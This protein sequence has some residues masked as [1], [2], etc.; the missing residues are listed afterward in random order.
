MDQG[1]LLRER[2]DQKRPTSETTNIFDSS[3]YRA[4][5]YP[6]QEPS[7]VLA[8]T[9]TEYGNRNIENEGFATRF[10]IKNAVNVIAIKT[11]EDDWYH[12]IPTQLF[13]NVDEFLASASTTRFRLKISYGS[14]M[15]GYAALL[16]ANRL[17]VHRALALSPQ[18]DITKTWDTRW[19]KELRKFT[20][21]RTMQPADV[22]PSCLYTI[23]YDPKDHDNLHFEKFEKVVPESQLQQLRISYG[24]HPTGGF[25]RLA[26]LLKEVVLSVINDKP[27]QGIASRLR[28][29]RRRVSRYHYSLAQACMRR[30]KWRW[31]LSIITNAVALEPL[32]SEYNLSAAIAADRNKDLNAAI[33]FSA[34]AV[35]ANPNHPHMLASLA[36]ALNKAGLTGQ[37]LHFMDQA[38]KLRPDHPGLIAQFNAMKR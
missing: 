23:I 2:L 14:S 8:F 35:A 11:C 10:L 1:Q 33:T 4:D 25:L 28:T 21:F 5:F 16:F 24:G 3:S 13:L 9:F 38:V 7:D 26:G 36:S 31:A 29:A 34:V 27:L 12:K 18:Y 6:S 30:K 19:I 32:N 22:H 20:C 37:A 17:G 15:G